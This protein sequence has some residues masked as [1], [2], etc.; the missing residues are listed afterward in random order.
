MSDAAFAFGPFE[1]LPADGRLLRQGVPVRL[2]THAFAI[3]A[4]L[5]ENAGKTV[6]KDELIARAWPDAPVDDNTLRVHVAA[7]RRALGDDGIDAR[8]VT[9]IPGRGYSFTAVIN[10]GPRGTAGMASPPRPAPPLPPGQST[11]AAPP[12]PPMQ[13][14][15][16]S[17]PAPPI[18]PALQAQAAPPVQPAQPIS[19][20][21]SLLS[22]VIGR[23]DVIAKLVDQLSRH[24]LLTI[25]GPGGI[26]KTTVAIAVAERARR[27]FRDGVW[28]AGLASLSDPGL[29]PNT[30]AAALGF[31]LPAAEPTAALA[32][33]LRGRRALVVLDNCEHVVNAAAI[34]AETILRLAPGIAILA[35]SREPLRADGEWLHRLAS[36][37]WPPPAPGLS[38]EQAMAFSAVQFFHQRVL[39]S[40]DNFTVNDGNLAAVLTIC[41][42]LEGVPLA[43]ELAAVRVEA[44]GVEGVAARL[45]DRFTLLSRGRRTALPRQQT[46]RAT[47][48]WS[49]ELLSRTEKTILHR[50]AVFRGGFTVDAAAAVAGTGGIAADEVFAGLANLVAKSLVVADRVGAAT[51]YRLLD[52]TRAYSLEKLEQTEE[53]AQIRRQHAA[54]FLALSRQAEIEWDT[55]IASDWLTDY[56]PQI[57]NLR[58]ALDW[59]SAPDGDLVMAVALTA[60]AVPLW[61]QMSLID[62]C[63]RRVTAALAFTDSM[64]DP[65]L[66]VQMKLF[67]ALGGSLLYVRGPTPETQAAWT[68]ALAYAETVGD[69]E[70]QLRAL[71]GLWVHHMNRGEFG[72]GLSL[73]RR[74]F[75]LAHDRGGAEDVAIGER[76]IGTSL[77]Y[78]GDQAEAR[79]HIEKMLAD[80]VEPVRRPPATRFRLD[81]KV[82]ARV[83]LARVIWIQGFPDQAWQMSQRTVQDARALNQPV[84]LCFALAE[85]GCPIAMLV[86]D[87][88]KG[89][90]YVSELLE[91]SHRHSLP[92]WQSWAHRFRGGLLI[93]QGAVPAGV[94]LLRNSLDRLPEASF[95]PRFTWFLGRLAIGLAGLGQIAEAMQAIEEA[96][97]RSERNQ[98]GWC[99]AEL[100]RVKGDLLLQGNAGSAAAADCYRQSLASARAQGAL[101]WELRTAISLARLFPDR[102]GPALAELQAVYRRF[103]EGFA[104]RDLQEA[105]QLLDAAP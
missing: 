89:D 33:Q 75:D 46:L 45:D 52:T 22:P 59:A 77:H 95:Q 55:R 76:I 18:R 103:T 11:Q 78:R 98:D 40:V 93:R 105:R 2:G 12:A 31:V 41:R 71:W 57:D 87:Y 56:A 84:T 72:T 66:T 74:F 88:G 35:T 27:A 67:A 39:S 9:S 43:L 83:A 96:L 15:A 90:Q 82:V 101:S 19:T 91:M 38:A 97:T 60:A 92:I 69:S 44:L 79:R 23:G 54:Y 1:L 26:G 48:D 85:S 86:G 49:Y 6:S 8:Y 25:L 37:D 50:L 80:Y 20:L 65:D 94:A 36:L 68:R 10:R 30:V 29:L 100:L 70:Y 53:T 21:P 5:V 81:Q 17:Q 47:M 32:E 28:F 4:I 7:L 58:A 104:T 42:L 99:L 3:L 73:G 63:H 61:V 24:R 51:R 34:L 64:P 102:D 14:A 13:A 16:P 62:E